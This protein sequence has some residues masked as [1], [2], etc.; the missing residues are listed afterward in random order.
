MF[1]AN[2]QTI[3]SI[4]SSYILLHIRSYTNP[5]QYQNEIWSKICVTYGKDFKHVFN[6]VAKIGN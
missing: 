4:T 3:K 2:Q 5:R 6:S 1:L